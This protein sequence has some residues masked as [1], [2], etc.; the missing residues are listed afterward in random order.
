MSV[1]VFFLLQGFITK[2]GEERWVYTNDWRLAPLFDVNTN[3]HFSEATEVFI[4]YDLLPA[5]TIEI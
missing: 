4:T 5:Q 3:D 1:L 2:L